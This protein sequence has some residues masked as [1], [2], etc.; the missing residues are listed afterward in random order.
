MNGDPPRSLHL[1]VFCANL[2]GEPA[3]SASGPQ[4]C[5]ALLVYLP[6]TDSAVPGVSLSRQQ[7]RELHKR[8]SVSESKSSHL[9]K[10]WESPT[11]AHCTKNREGSLSFH[12]RSTVAVQPWTRRSRQVSWQLLSIFAS[13]KQVSALENQLSIQPRS[14][15]RTPFAD[16]PGQ[17]FG[18][19]AQ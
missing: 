16:R 3:L 8:S 5:L 1:F 15:N 4:D 14:T 13:S 2:L 9:K 17:P 11:F 6:T 7:K 10:Q 18:D 12:V 19:S